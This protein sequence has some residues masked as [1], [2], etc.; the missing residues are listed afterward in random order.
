MILTAGLL[1]LTWAT[2]RAV[3][4]AVERGAA[5]LLAV[6]A[7]AVIVP[8]LLAS[9]WAAATNL[10][11]LDALSIPVMARAHGVGNAFGF[12]LL[13][14]LGWRRALSLAPVFPPVTS[15]R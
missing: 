11:G 6:S 12:T 3:V 4:P 2:L 13:G 15:P 1:A 7:V 14:L 8:M 9:H 5:V 10:A